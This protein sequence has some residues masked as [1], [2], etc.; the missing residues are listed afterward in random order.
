MLVGLISKN[1]ILIVEFARKLQLAGAT[2][3]EAIKSAAAVRAK[4]RTAEKILG[5]IRALPAGRSLIGRDNVHSTASAARPSP[6]RD[7]TTRSSISS[8]VACVSC[9][10]AWTRR[11]STEAEVEAF[12]PL[13]KK[14]RQML[15]QACEKLQLSARAYNRI[16]KIARTIADLDGRMPPGRFSC[17]RRSSPPIRRPGSGPASRRVIRATPTGTTRAAASPRWRCRSHSP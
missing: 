1:A 6:T 11:R 2:R 8:C 4:P 7:T 17:A 13:V 12:C 10:G 5:A 14:D 3:F 15:H 16:I 9:F